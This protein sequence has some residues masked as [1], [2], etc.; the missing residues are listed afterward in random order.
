MK[1]IGKECGKG[2]F[3]EK[4]FLKGEE[5]FCETPLTSAPPSATFDALWCD[6]CFRYIGTRQSVLKRMSEV[7]GKSTPPQLPFFE[8]LC[9]PFSEKPAVPCENC[10]VCR[11]VF[12][13]EECKSCATVEYHRVLC[14][15]LKKSRKLVEILKSLSAQG[16]KKIGGEKANYFLK[17][18]NK[19]TNKITWQMTNT[20]IWHRSPRGF[21]LQRFN[22]ISNRR[23][24]PGIRLG[25]PF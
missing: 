12:C 10:Q 11:A 20:T 9:P 2:L 24:A 18:T 8:E 15:S 14:E 16:E 7:C 22:R 25:H 3:A 21:T 19:Q 4:D 5:I 17:Q 23:L 1:Y 13:S 6:R